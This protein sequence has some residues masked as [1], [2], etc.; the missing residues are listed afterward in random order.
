MHAVAGGFL[1]CTENWTLEADLVVDGAGA[2]TGAGTGVLDGL[3]NC[4]SNFGHDFQNALSLVFSI[5]GSE[6][7]SA[8]S[9]QFQ[10]THVSAPYA[11]EGLLNYTMF[12]TPGAGPP[13]V[14]LV[15]R[16]PPNRAEGTV[17]VSAT[18]D[19]GSV[20]TG[21]HQFQLTCTDC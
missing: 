2:I 21:T 1:E 10:E 19:N 15:P 3:E 6:T 13:P 14:L 9:L 16:V 4:D 11:H 17:T 8:L 5:T 7:D 18:V 20:A 12:L